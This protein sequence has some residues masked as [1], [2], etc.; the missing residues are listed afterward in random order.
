ME[1]RGRGGGREESRLKVGVQEE[2]I[3]KRE[4][5]EERTSLP[6][7]ARRGPIDSGV[8]SLVLAGA[9]RDRNGAEGGQG[10]EGE[11]RDLIPHSKQRRRCRHQNQHLST[12]Q[13]RA[14]LRT[15]N[16]QSRLTQTSLLN[17]STPGTFSF[18]VLSVPVARLVR[19]CRAATQAKRITKRRLTKKL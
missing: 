2:E 19:V 1:K 16:D 13:S 17:I 3:D 9:Q 10:G 7:G 4:E 6:F 5:R 8:M 15:A 12:P 14:T 18:Q 11:R